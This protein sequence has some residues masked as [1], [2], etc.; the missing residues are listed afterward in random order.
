MSTKR[1]PSSGNIPIAG[2]SSVGMAASSSSSSFTEAPCNPGQ[3]PAPF[4]QAESMNMTPFMTNAN[5]RIISPPA[6]DDAKAPS[7]MPG[8]PAWMSPTSVSRTYFPATLAKNVE[9]EED[10]GMCGGYDGVVDGQGLRTEYDV[11]PYEIHAWSSHSANFLPHNIQVDRPHDQASRWS[12]NANNHRQYITLRLEH[13]ALVKFKV[14]GGMNQDT[15]TELLYSGLRNDNEPETI[16]VKQRLSGYIQPLLAHDQKFNFSV[17]YVE[18]RGTMDPQ[19][20]Q[21]IIRDFEQLKERE[22]VRSC[23]KFFRERNYTDAFKALQQQ[24]SVQFETPLLTQLHEALVDKADYDR[25]EQLLQRA[26]QSGIF[27]TCI[28]KIPYRAKWGTA[29]DPELYPCPS[30]RGGHQMCV[31]SENREAYLYGGWDGANNMGDLW[32]FK[33]DTG[34]W[35]CISSNTRDHGGPGPCSCHSMCFDSITKCLYIMGRYVEHEHRANIGLENDLYCYDTIRD[36]WLMLSENTE[37]LGGPKLVFDAQMV[38]DPRFSSIYVYGG[39][40]LQPNNSDTD[41]VYS[42]LYKFDLRRHAWTMLKPDAHMHDKD[43][44]VRGRYFHSMTIDPQLQRLYVVSSKRDVAT[45]GDL[46]IYDIASNTF[47]ERTQDLMATWG[48]RQPATQQRYLAEHPHYTTGM[49]PQ[50]TALMAPEASEIHPHHVHL[51]QDGRSVMSTLDTERQE[52]YVMASVQNESSSALPLQSMMS[53]RSRDVMGTAELHAAQGAYASYSSG[54]G[55]LPCSSIMDSGVRYTV[56]P[57]MSTMRPKSSRRDNQ[58]K[59]VEECVLMVV[60]CY[61]IPTETWTEVYHSAR[62][63]AALGMA[64]GS[65]PSA[66]FAQDWVYDRQTRKHFMFGGNPNWP[67]NKSA[68]FNDT[69]EMSM[70]R[71]SPQDILRRA[72]Y[73]VRQRRYLDMC[74]GLASQR[75]PN[76]VDEIKASAIPSPN[77]MDEKSESIPGLGMTVSGPPAASTSKGG[78]AQALAYL[79]Q[80][81]SPLVNHSDP[82]ESH[83]FRALSTAL[84]Q[85]SANQSVVKPAPSHELLRKER[86][87]VYNALLFYFPESGR[88]PDSQ[89]DE[90]VPMVLD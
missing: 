21:P 15:M 35:T 61:H 9:A 27:G 41:Y 49:E 16:S 10:M 30:P 90:L 64:P 56:S 74:A 85:I 44:H 7:A 31:D 77:L 32:V 33:M 14:F 67:T 62:S 65:Y 19:I 42:G 13:P 3:Q 12:T 84:F 55:F 48:T 46:F 39:K 36:E 45:P 5:Y 78:T 88:Q 83:S 43:Q 22:V 68:R 82:S 24:S 58:R 6:K 86:A 66:R 11:L 20:M 81:V 59:S 53:M 54:A 89:L 57:T 8:L 37:V 38:F 28:A 26:E 50:R 76:C 87:D 23:L 72:L 40:V 47:Y 4:H 80:C 2:M 34:R 71:P 63:P 79:Q 17:W 29:A 70:T 51:V 69:W 25:A 52:L 60:L 75:Q 73:L 1:T 18:L